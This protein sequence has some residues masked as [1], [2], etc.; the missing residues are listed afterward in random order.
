MWGIMAPREG[1]QLQINFKEIFGPNGN[2]F[3]SIGILLRV[4]N[5]FVVM[6]LRVF[7]KY[8]LY[9]TVRLL[10]FIFSDIVRSG[11]QQEP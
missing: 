10:I 6:M 2:N 5:L 7:Y 9:L 8:L 4:W 3:S 1:K 11:Y